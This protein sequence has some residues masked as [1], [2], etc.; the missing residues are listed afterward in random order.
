MVNCYHIMEFILFILH[1]LDG[2]FCVL[3]TCK[4]ES[5][6]FLEK[7]K[8]NDVHYGYLNRWSFICISKIASTKQYWEEFIWCFV[9]ILCQADERMECVL[10]HLPRGNWWASRCFEQHA[11]KVWDSFIMSMFMWGNL[12]IYQWGVF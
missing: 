11:H 1:V 4:Y 6:I 7:Q 5:V 8:T 10:L 12:S 3:M 2:V 9:S